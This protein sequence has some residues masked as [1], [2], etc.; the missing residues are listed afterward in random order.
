MLDACR[1]PTSVPTGT[2]GLWE[3]HRAPIRTA[4]AR[5][6]LGLPLSAQYTALCRRT[7]ATMHNAHGEVV[8]ED[9][10]REL[11][12]HLPFLLAAHG[13][14]LVSGLGLGCVLRGLLSKPEVAHVDVI[15]IDP[16][17]VQLVRKEFENDS[18]VSLHMGDALRVKW[19]KGRRW[20]YA[21]H[22]IWDE[23]KDLHVLHMKLIAR[24]RSRVRN[25]QGA[26]QFP[27]IIRDRWSDELL[28]TVRRPSWVRSGGNLHAR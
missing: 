28:G 7:W 27:R 19:P 4:Y 11:R 5:D 14:V 17:V 24:Y 3:I 18:R 15:E 20:D 21:W 16:H 25:E 8:M 10:P 2:V 9:T 13:D 22:D 12:R 23:E 6:F 26:W 1:V